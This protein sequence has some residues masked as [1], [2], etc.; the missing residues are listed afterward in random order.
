[1]GKQNEGKI[2]QTV[3]HIWVK[4]RTLEDDCP[5]PPHAHLTW[6]YVT[7]VLSEVMSGVPELRSRGLDETK[8]N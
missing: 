8:N 2:K 1:M 4:E 6:S 7:V 5:H 3:K